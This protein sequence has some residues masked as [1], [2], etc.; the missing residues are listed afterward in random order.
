MGWVVMRRA[1]GSIRQRKAEGTEAAGE[2]Q[3]LK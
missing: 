2:K 1:G 3:G